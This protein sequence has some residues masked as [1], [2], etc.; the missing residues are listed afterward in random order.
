MNGLTCLTRKLGGFYWF[1][2]CAFIMAQGSIRGESDFWLDIPAGKRSD[3]EAMQLQRLIFETIS[4]AEPLSRSASHPFQ[5]HIPEAISPWLQPTASA[6]GAG[7]AEILT[8][9]VIDGARVPNI[10]EMIEAYGLEG[11][12]LFGEGADERLIAS[13]PWLVQL[14]PG[15]RFIRRFFLEG[16]EQ[17]SDQA[18]WMENWGIFIRSRSG[19]NGLSGHFRKFTKIKDENGQW[20][21]FRFWDTDFMGLYLRQKN[22]AQLPLVLRL[23]DPAVIERALVF[24]PFDGAYSVRLDL[25]GDI[26][27]SLQPKIGFRREEF[28]AVGVAL[29]DRRAARAYHAS[30]RKLLGGEG[31]DEL[32]AR[33]SEARAACSALGITQEGL[34]GTFILLGTIFD[35]RF[36]QGDAFRAYWSKA[37][38]S[39]D[40]RFKTYLSALKA[41]IL[42]ARLPLKPWW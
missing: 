11:R 3:A 35:R 34:P 31:L 5:D 33:I 8:F 36:W 37:R 38:T 21:F 15:N 26:A 10:P 20:L 40:M 9:V 17:R 19:L 42:K 1:S 16:C 6:T 14:E 18:L 24:N 29:A 28:D 12:S 2:G 7:I 13:G 30:Y 32:R 27:Q 25:S 22:A 39:P 4:N 41:Q 23:L